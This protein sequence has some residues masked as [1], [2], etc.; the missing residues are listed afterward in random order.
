MNTQHPPV[1][2]QDPRTTDALIDHILSRYHDAHRLQIPELVELSRRVERVHAAHA[3]VPAGLADKLQQIG[4]ELD[5]HMQKEER[6][7]F[8]AMRRQPTAQLVQPIAQM[9]RDHAD[10]G[11]LLEEVM[12]LTNNY[13]LPADACGSWRALF[14]GVAQLQEDLMQHIHLENTVLFPRFEA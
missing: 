9:R 1:T 3:D 12:R 4:N 13:A 11:E 8:P 7:L 5:A 6:I 14:T 2:P 10:H